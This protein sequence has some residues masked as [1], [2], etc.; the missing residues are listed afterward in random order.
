[1]AT[2]IIEA[3]RHVKLVAAVVVAIH[4]EH[5]IGGDSNN[6]VC[7]FMSA[8]SG[9]MTIGRRWIQGQ[10]DFQ[11]MHMRNVLH[12]G[13]VVLNATMIEIFGRL[14]CGRNSCRGELGGGHD[15]CEREQLC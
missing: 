1:M 6:P 11:L 14:R 8:G 4:Q 3:P 12:L 15:D 7:A 5:A 10:R 13:F 2:T 9:C